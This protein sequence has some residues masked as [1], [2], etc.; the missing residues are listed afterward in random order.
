MDL[1]NDAFSAR[2]KRI[3]YHL[4]SNGRTALRERAAESVGKH[5]A[6]NRG[7]AYAPMIVKTR[8]LNGDRSVYGV[9]RYVGKGDN[10]PLRVTIVVVEKDLA[11]AIIDLC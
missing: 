3:F 8:V 4:L 2:Q 7:E 5:R 6:K 9:R 10:I 11:G 1:A